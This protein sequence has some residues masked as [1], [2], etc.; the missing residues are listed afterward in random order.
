MPDARRLLR[1]HPGVGELLE[2][3][4]FIEQPD[5]AV[6]RVHEIGERLDRAL[7][8]R[9]LHVVNREQRQQPQRGAVQGLDP[10]GAVRQQRV[11][12]LQLLFEL[13]HG[14][15]RLPAHEHGRERG[16]MRDRAH[17]FPGGIEHGDRI[18][19]L[20]RHVRQHLLERGSRCDRF[21]GRWGQEIGE[22]ALRVARDLVFAHERAERT[23]R[24]VFVR[25]EYGIQQRPPRPRRQ[26]WSLFIEDLDDAL[27]ECVARR[28][29]GAQR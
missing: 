3:P 12:L 17:E 18:G 8:Q 26:A 14:G 29:H 19:V 21:G 6:T 1:A 22:N 5:G 11:I 15:A 4:R 24:A 23:R 13:P 7:Q 2:R 16:Q 25:G 28:E 10:L 9:L 20:R 27:G